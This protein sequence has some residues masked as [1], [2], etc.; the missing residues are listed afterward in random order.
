MKTIRLLTK[1][2][3]IQNEIYWKRRYTAR[4]GVILERLYPN[5]KWKDLFIERNTRVVIEQAQPQ[6]GDEHNMSEITK[7]CCPYVHRLLITELQ[8]WKP[9]LTMQPEDIPEV[10]PID[11][12]DF[13]PILKELHEIEELDVVFG[14]RNVKVSFNW[15]MWKLSVLDAKRLGE[16]CLY[17]DNLRIVRVH[18]TKLSDSH[19]QALLQG[20]IKTKNL[21]ELD[22]SHCEIG[23]EGALC[24]AKVMMEH[25]TLAKIKLNNNKIRTIGGQGLGFALLHNSCCP[26]IHLDLKLNPLE[27]DGTMGILRALV[28]GDKPQELSLAGCL[29]GEITPIRVAQTINL[30]RSLEVLDISSNFFGAEGGEVGKNSILI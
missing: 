22:L 12:V 9:P 11:H 18:R 4:F 21:F 30:N 16:A 7:L 2:N 26:L 1:H 29:F 23:D 19:C 24:V 28:R 27:H 8:A 14:M 25:P 6:Y 15:N 3:L 13:G 17:L 20:L 10:I 5:W